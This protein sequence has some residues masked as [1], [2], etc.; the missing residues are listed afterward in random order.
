MTPVLLLISTRI[1]VA[2]PGDTL[3][4]SYGFGDIAATVYVAKAIALDEGILSKAAGLTRVLQLDKVIDR[5]VIRGYVDGGDLLG[6][7]DVTA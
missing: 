1:W 5:I 4:Q 3:D 7:R 2:P 6:H